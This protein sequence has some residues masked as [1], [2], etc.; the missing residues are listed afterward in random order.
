MAD[1]KFS[2]MTVATTLMAADYLPIVQGGG[3]CTI[4][5]T[6]LLTGG[7]GEPQLLMAS[8]GQPVQ[9]VGNDGFSQLLIDGGNNGGLNVAGD[10]SLSSFTSGTTFSASVSGLALVEVMNGAQFI[11]RDIANTTFIE[12]DTFAH[13]VTITATAGVFATYVPANP[14]NWPTSVPSLINTAL[15][16]LAAAIFSLSAGTLP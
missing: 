4:T 6:L 13:Q 1:L 7:V 2:M 3:N 16:Q 14:G 11:A 12:M 10:A 9:V 15:D 8:V 5:K